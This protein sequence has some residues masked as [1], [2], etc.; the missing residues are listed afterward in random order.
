VRSE[1]S[2]HKTS[3]RFGFESV[4]VTRAG[5]AS[6]DDTYATNFVELRDGQ[7]GAVRGHEAEIGYSADK[8]IILE[9][10]MLEMCAAARSVPRRGRDWLCRFS[11]SG[12]L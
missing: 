11:L 10:L 6:I 3:V 9:K 4:D 5:L 8:E 2:K 12:A 7:A 1:V